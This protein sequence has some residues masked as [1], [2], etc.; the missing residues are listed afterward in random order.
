MDIYQDIAYIICI[1]ILSFRFIRAKT[2]EDYVEF[3]AFAVFVMA[4][5]SF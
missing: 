5:T 4:I 1:I 2:L 3:I